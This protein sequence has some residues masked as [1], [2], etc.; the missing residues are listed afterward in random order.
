ML[1]LYVKLAH[2]SGKDKEAKGGAKEAPFPF[3]TVL[4]QTGTEGDG[5]VWHVMIEGLFVG[6]TF[7]AKESL[8]TLKL[9]RKVPDDTNPPSGE[10][11]LL[12]PLP[13]PADPVRS[14]VCERVVKHPLAPW[15]VHVPLSPAVAAVEGG[16]D[17]GD[18]AEEYAQLLGFNAEVGDGDDGEGDAEADGVDDDDDEDD[19]QVVVVPAGAQAQLF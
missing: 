11:T 4:K 19:E 6:L 3:Y 9:T 17:G 12:V 16:T 18:F 2:E 7:E 15:V 10:Y 1:K 13:R 14:I 5:V 8:L